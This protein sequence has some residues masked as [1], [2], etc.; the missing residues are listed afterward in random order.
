MWTKTA[1]TMRFADQAWTERTSQPNFTRVMTN[2][3]LSNAASG[4]G[5]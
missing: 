4:V 3:T 2:S 5:R 1:S